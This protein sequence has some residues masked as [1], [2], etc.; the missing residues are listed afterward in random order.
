MEYPLVYMGLY[1]FY[2]DY[3]A[4]TNLLSGDAHP[5]MILQQQYH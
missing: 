5:N 3:E 2:M 1:G 4:L